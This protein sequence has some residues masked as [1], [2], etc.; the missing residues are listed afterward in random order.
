M[1]KPDEII[2]SRRR[3]LSISIDSFGRL[4]VR[5]PI[6]FDEERIFAFL[7]EKESWILRKQAERKGAGMDL[8]PDNLD[9]YEFLLLGKKTKIQLVEGTKVGFDAEQNVIYLPHKNAKERLV[10][11][12]KE[13]AKRI[14]ATVTQQK[15]KEMQTTFQSVSISSAKTRWGT[16]SFDNKIRY[17][18][19]LL[20]APKEVV[21]YVAVHE[22]AHTK[23]K[24]H[25]PQFWAEVTKYVPDWKQ[26]RKWL[27][28]HA[29]LME[30]F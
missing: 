29:V 25:S 3:T 19:R 16:C 20:Y 21:E 6:R 30:I 5:A 7:K 27:K 28:T 9:G 24:N 15:A 13:N 12:L 10:K 8:P 1:I 26:K 2:R 11:W 22:L 23:H 18:F 17:S 14:L 4:I